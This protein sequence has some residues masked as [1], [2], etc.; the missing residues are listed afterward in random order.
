VNFKLTESAGT[1]KTENSAVVKMNEN[2]LMLAARYLPALDP[3]DTGHPQVN[4]QSPAVGK[5]RY[6]ITPSPADG[7]KKQSGKTGIFQRFK[8]AAHGRRKD[9]N[10]GNHSLRQHPAESIADIFNFGQFR[11]FQQPD[12]SD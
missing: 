11:H 4:E 7:S 5:I 8:T 12:F 6:Q 10:A 1:F 3:D 9:L 2:M